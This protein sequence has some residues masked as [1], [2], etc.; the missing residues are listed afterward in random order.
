MIVAFKSTHLTW[1]FSKPKCT[2]LLY[3]NG[4]SEI[5]DSI[6]LTINIIVLAATYHIITT[7]S[8]FDIVSLNLITFLHTYHHRAMIID[9]GTAGITTIFPLILF[10]LLSHIHRSDIEGHDH[11]GRTIFN[12]GTTSRTLLT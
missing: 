4:V 3:G 10:L 1:C 12:A 5:E 8:A 6:L 9:H 11:Q 7:T 2:G